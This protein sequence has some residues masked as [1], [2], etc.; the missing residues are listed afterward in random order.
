MRKRVVRTEHLWEGNMNWKENYV[1]ALETAG[2]FENSAHR[3]RFKELM[4]CYADY[5]FF[6]KG[7]CKCMYLSAWDEE[8]F[9]VMLEILADMSLGKEKNT[10]EMR[11]KGESLAEERTDEET[12]VYQLSNAF[13]D[14]VPF[15]L[16]EELR[17]GAQT[18]YIISQALKAADVIDGV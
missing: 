1:M 8:H 16:E 9:C 14:N 3:T 5:P 4:D 15:Q 7:L 13:L 10:K 12:Y 17:I 6:S 2:L 18:R 11:N